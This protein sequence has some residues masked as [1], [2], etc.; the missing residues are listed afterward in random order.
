M[1]RALLIALATLTPLTAAAQATTDKAQVVTAVQ[2][3]F[4]SMATRAA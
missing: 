3:F 4:D 1:K 2:Q